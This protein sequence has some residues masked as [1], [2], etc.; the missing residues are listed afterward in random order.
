[1]KNVAIALLDQMG[2]ERFEETE[3]KSDKGITLGHHSVLILPGEIALGGGLAKNLNISRRIAVAESLERTTVDRLKLSKASCFEWHLDSFPTTCGFAAGFEREPTRMRSY[4][5]AV[6]RWAWS[7]WIDYGFDLEE[8]T[9]KSLSNLTQVLLHPFEKVKFFVKKIKVSI[10]PSRA[11]YF[12]VVIG[13][14]GKGVFPGS[15][16]C[17]DP[18]NIWLHAAV[19]ARRHFLVTTKRPFVKLKRH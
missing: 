12:G 9:P 11:L 6:E 3:I 17:S 10:V 19:E 15:R 16:V 8:T 7:Q 2:H 4:C 5:E 13:E 14:R 18:E 1:M